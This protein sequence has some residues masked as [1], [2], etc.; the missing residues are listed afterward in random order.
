[1]RGLF[2]ARVLLLQLYSLSQDGALCVWQ[3]DTPPEGLKLKAPRGWKAD[4]LQR[5][6][7]EEEEDEEEGE[8]ETTIRGKAM[9]AEQEKVGKVK[10]SRLAK[11]V[12]KA[13]YSGS[14]LLKWGLYWGGPKS[15]SREQAPCL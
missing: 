12:S 3:C 6:K 9:P 13:E 1:M 8:R 10:Y 4:L 11:Y 7:E 14:I 2:P 15:W 5:Q